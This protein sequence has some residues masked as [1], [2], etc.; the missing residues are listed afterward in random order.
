MLKTDEN[1]LIDTA[2]S[3]FVWGQS[4]YTT[5]DGI[6]VESRRRISSAGFREMETPRIERYITD[7]TSVF[8]SGILGKLILVHEAGDAFL[9]IP[10]LPDHTPVHAD[11]HG[12][13]AADEAHPE[14]LGPG[15]KI[16][17]GVLEIPNEEQAS[18]TEPN[19]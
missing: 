1:V 2:Y 14:V 16:G 12:M 10:H 3:C 7:P 19:P 6:N 5:V 13:D 11:M 9:S 4:A 18:L 15:A 17:C 8:S